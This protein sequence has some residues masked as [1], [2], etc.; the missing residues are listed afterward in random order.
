M[1]WGPPKRPPEG[2]FPN[3]LPAG[4]F[5]AEA[6]EVPPNGVDRAVFDPV[7]PKIEPPEAPGPGFAVFP[8]L[9]KRDGGPPE[10]LAPNNG[11]FGVLLPPAADDPKLN[12]I[13][14][15]SMVFAGARSWAWREERKRCWPVELRKRARRLPSVD[16]GRVECN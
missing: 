6:L 8:A 13:S 3:R 12:A 9:L 16:A 10:L 14:R 11:L 2:L 15:S 4:L 1:L 5:A 7:P